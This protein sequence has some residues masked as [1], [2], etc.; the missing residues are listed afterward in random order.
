MR[1]R[2]EWPSL[3][4]WWLT[5]WRGEVKVD[6]EELS[7]GVTPWDT[8]SQPDTLWSSATACDWARGEGSVEPC[9]WMTSWQWGLLWMSTWKAC[10]FEG[11]NLWRGNVCAHRSHQKAVAVEQGLSGWNDEPCVC[12]LRESPETARAEWVTVRVTNQR[13]EVFFML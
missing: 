13:E 6:L 1:W 9:S 2:I 4:V 5:L 3:R 11:Q 10:C 7:R 12:E 8:G